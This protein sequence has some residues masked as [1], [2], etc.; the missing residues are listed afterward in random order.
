ML[1]IANYEIMTKTYIIENGQKPI[2]EQIREVEE[3]R[4]S[5]IFICCLRQVIRCIKV[6]EVVCTKGGFYLPCFHIVKLVQCFLWNAECSQ[7]TWKVRKFVLQSYKSRIILHLYKAQAVHRGEHLLRIG[8]MDAYLER[9]K[10]C[11]EIP[12]LQLKQDNAGIT[13][14]PATHVLCF[15]ILL[16]DKEKLMG[17]KDTKAKEYLS[18]NARFADLCN[19]VLFD[20]E[21]IIQ[22]SDLLERDTA[23]VLS[24]LGKSG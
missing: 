18:D 21:Q 3:A 12:Q 5:P 9:A 1:C 10:S 14:V 24:V 22:A 8:E 17:A 20:G 6:H 7:K 13:D 15:C 23:E 19:V 2:K 11:F 4:K 16:L